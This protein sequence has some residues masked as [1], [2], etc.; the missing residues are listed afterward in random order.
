M[1]NTE[2]ERK[3]REELQ[4][5]IKQWR[6]RAMISEKYLRMVLGEFPEANAYIL[7]KAK[8]NTE[9]ADV[10]CRNCTCWK[11]KQRER[12]TNEP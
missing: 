7:D 5:Q 3:Y 11:S 9:R 6:E 8:C 4:S 2:I 1:T 12:P 10:Q